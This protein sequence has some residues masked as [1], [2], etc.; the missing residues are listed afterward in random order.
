MKSHVKYWAIVVVPVLV[1]IGC[2]SKPPQKER[3][4][5]KV[6]VDHPVIR[7]EVNNDEFTGWLEAVQTIVV[8]SQVAGE[9]KVNYIKDKEGKVVKEADLLFELDPDA[10]KIQIARSE[11]TVK[12]FEAEKEGAVKELARLEELLKSGGATQ[13]Q[14]D[15]VRADAG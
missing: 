15:K 1:L 10:F 11:A 6:T 14:I 4:A 9:L 13:R 8:Q 5:P 12:K 2:S 3:E 7:K